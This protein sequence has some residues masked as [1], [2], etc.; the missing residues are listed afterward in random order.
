[1]V[2][3]ESGSGR[4]GPENQGCSPGERGGAGA[5]AMEGKGDWEN[6]DTLERRTGGATQGN[7]KGL[8]EGLVGRS[9]G[10]VERRVGEGQSRSDAES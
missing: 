4:S 9:T 3:A 1:M 10:E 2:G 6:E 5:S 8:D 7:E